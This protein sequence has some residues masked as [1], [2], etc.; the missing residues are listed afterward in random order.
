[1]EKNLWAIL[2][3]LPERIS[4][5]NFGWIS[6]EIPGYFPKGISWRIHAGVSGEVSGAILCS[7]TGEISWK[8]LENSL[9]KF[10]IDLNF[11]GRNLQQNLKRTSQ[12]ILGESLE[13]YL[14]QIAV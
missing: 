6:G 12:K 14:K 7:I 3:R 11:E 8:F 5:D 10:L 9:K 13:K 1:M 2:R 4:E